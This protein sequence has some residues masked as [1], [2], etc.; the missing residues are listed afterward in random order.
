MWLDRQLNVF[1]STFFIARDRIGNY[2]L[3]VHCAI[4]A[5]HIFI[6]KE[7]TYVFIVYI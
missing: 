6:F 4:R 3:E 1:Q 7:T 2:N 5:A